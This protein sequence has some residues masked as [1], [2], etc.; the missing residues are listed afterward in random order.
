MGIAVQRERERARSL[1]TT[2]TTTTWKHGN[3]QEIENEPFCFSPCSLR[4]QRKRE[5]NDLSVG[6][7]HISPFERNVLCC[8]L[9]GKR[10]GRWLPLLGV[11]NHSTLAGSSHL[12]SY[13]PFSFSFSLFL[14]VVR[15]SVR[16]F[17]FDSLQLHFLL[18]LL[19]SFFPSAF[20]GTSIWCAG[21]SPRFICLA[22]IPLRS[23]CCI[24]EATSY[25][26]GRETGHRW[27]E[28]KKERRRRCFVYNSCSPPHMPISTGACTGEK[29]KTDTFSDTSRMKAAQVANP[30]F[31]SAVAPSNL[32]SSFCVYYP[33]SSSCFNMFFSFFSFFSFEFSSASRETGAEVRL[34]T[35]RVRRP[36]VT[37]KTLMYN[38]GTNRIDGRMAQSR[39]HRYTSP[40]PISLERESR[41]RHDCQWIQ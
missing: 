37:S 39:F 41:E 9:C 15:L 34:L 13:F 33:S 23:C 3:V 14:S 31:S 6:A 7:R 25:Q 29:R 24:K 8:E 22:V 5:E 1:K 35:I 2:T 17:S 36:P 18:L 38:E 21:L 4:P 11:S 28:G 10:I 19:L 16:P 27:I 30:Q 26:C 12:L 40:H 20:A 32:Q